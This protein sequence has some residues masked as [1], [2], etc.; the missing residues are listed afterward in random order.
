MSAT[1]PGEPQNLAG[2]PLRR[3]ERGR[4]RQVA[5]QVPEM[6]V[7]PQAASGPMRSAAVRDPGPILPPPGPYLLEAFP[8]IPYLRHVHPLR[9]TKPGTSALAAISPNARLRM[10][11]SRA[12]C[13]D[14]SL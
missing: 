5:V 12:P 14:R 2:D 13:C 9:D 10:S 7:L 8:Q 6:I 1:R 4:L 3:Q 11:G